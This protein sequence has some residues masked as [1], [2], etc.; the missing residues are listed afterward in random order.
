MIRILFVIISAV[1]FF[2]SF[3]FAAEIINETVRQKG[4]SIVFEFDIVG[5]EAETE[6]SVI[7]TIKDRQYVANDLLRRR[8]I[9]ILTAG[10]DQ[11]V[12]DG[13]GHSPF[14]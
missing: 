1:A 13:S 10:D 5:E 7:L 2:P 12:S 3:T 14:T 4:N 6:V 11:P 9:N 8:T